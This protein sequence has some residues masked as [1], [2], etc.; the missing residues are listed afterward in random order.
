MKEKN[1]ETIFVI[2]DC[3]YTISK[4]YRSLEDA[5]TYVLREYIEKIV[6]SYIKAIGENNAY[7]QNVID[8]IKADVNSLYNNNCIEDCFYIYNVDLI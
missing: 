2:D 1:V 4:A 8:D 6:P 5:R 7:Y 3:N